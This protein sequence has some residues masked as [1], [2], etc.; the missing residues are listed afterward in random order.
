VRHKKQI[1]GGDLLDLFGNSGEYEKKAT[2]THTKP[3][4]ARKGAQCRMGKGGLPGEK[5]RGGKME[6]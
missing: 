3:G 2:P 6:T 5:G 1:A 4:A